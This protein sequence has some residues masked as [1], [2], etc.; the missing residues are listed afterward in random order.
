MTWAPL[1]LQKTLFE[2]LSNDATLATLI[3]DVYDSTAVP[4]NV[5]FPYVTI[6]GLSLEDRSNHTTRGFSCDFIIHTW[7]RETGHGRKKV[8]LIQAEID[9]ILHAVD[10]C[11]D[12]WNIIS[13]RQK[14]VDVI[15]DTD[16]V[17]LHGIQTFNLLIGEA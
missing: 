10:I 16:N 9:R 15:V 11:I 13:L 12:G 4:Q 8:Q 2:E 6:D 1:E 7:Y 17:T 3:D 5:A 14:V